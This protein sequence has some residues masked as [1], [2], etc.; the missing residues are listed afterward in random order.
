MAIAR[1]TIID[2]VFFGTA[3]PASTYLSSGAQYFHEDLGTFFG[4]EAN[5][6]GAKA[7]LSDGGF[8]PEAP[9]SD[10]LDMIVL[11]SPSTNQVATIVQS[12]LAEIGIRVAI[13]SDQIGPWINRLFGGDYDLAMLSVEAQATTGFGSEYPYLGYRSGFPSNLNNVNDP[14]LDALLDAAVVAPD[15]Q[16]ALDAWRAVQQYDLDAGL[17]QIQIVTARYV[18]GVNPELGSY[19][20]SNTG[21]HPFAKDAQPPV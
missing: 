10:T 4:T 1:Q 14:D 11:S 7:A 2:T 21:L 17:Y 18:E 8:D 13:F 5:V 6:D 15:G 16:P 12:N 19:Q 20:T 9:T 3:V